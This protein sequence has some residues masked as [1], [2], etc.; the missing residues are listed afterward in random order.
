MIAGGRA[1]EWGRRREGV[2]KLRIRGEPDRGRM[3]RGEGRTG[4]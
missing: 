3:K 4:E 2:S 1:V